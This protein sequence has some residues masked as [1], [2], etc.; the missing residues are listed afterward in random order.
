MKIVI[1]C[2]NGAAYKAA[3]AVYRGLG[4]EVTM[5]ANTPD[6]MNTTQAVVRHTRKIFRKR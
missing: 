2:A 3:E 1:D 4:A 6:G 5:I